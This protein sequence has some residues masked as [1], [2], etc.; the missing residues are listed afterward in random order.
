MNYLTYS[1]EK[2]TRTNVCKTVQ[3]KKHSTQ[4]YTVTDRLLNK[5]MIKIT[6]AV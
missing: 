1:K 3:T 5:I 2:H 6:N 4:L